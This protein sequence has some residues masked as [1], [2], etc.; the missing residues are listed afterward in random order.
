MKLPN[1]IAVAAVTV[2]LAL[3][4]PAGAA[5]YSVFKASVSLPGF[6]KGKDG[7]NNDILIKRT[8]STN[9]IINLAL[10]RTTKTKVPK[11]TV[12]V[13]AVNAMDLQQT[14]GI[15]DP[16]LL[17]VDFTNPA[18]PVR[19]ATILQPDTT[20]PPTPINFAENHISNAFLRVGV[21]RAKVVGV[22]NIAPGGANSV[23]VSGT[24]K[25]K[26]TPTGPLPI[27]ANSFAGEFTFTDDDNVTKTAIVL[28]G[29]FTCSGKI[30]GT[31][32][33]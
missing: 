5:D 9:A 8:L 25:R 17:V 24:L 12:L 16:Q 2:L 21:G 7:A 6:V 1:I 20:T 32:T 28:A 22:G 18:A 10:G 29:K 19:L 33:F 27:I 11:T 30:L 4:K 31:V 15:T 23:N 26:P 3:T 13:G 14:N